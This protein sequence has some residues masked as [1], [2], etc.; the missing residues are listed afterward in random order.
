MRGHGHVH[1]KRTTL[2]SNSPVIRA[3]ETGK[4]QRSREKVPPTAR[5]YQS[6]RTGKIGYQGTRHLK[7]LG[8]LEA[9]VAIHFPYCI[10]LDQVLYKRFEL[11]PTCMIVIGGHGHGP[12]ASQGIPVQICSSDGSVDSGFPCLQCGPGA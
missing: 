9:L 2:W 11:K 10:F 4:L 5:K 6:K 3:F 12:T 1:A 7:K 8:T